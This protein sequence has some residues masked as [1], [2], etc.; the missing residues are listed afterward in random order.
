MADSEE[1]VDGARSNDW[2]DFS[3]DVGASLSQLARASLRRDTERGRRAVRALVKLFKRVALAT[4]IGLIAGALGASFLWSMQFACDFFLA[5]ERLG[6]SGTSPRALFLL[7]FAGLAIV[8]AYKRSGLSVDAG[9]DQVVESLGNEESR[10][11]LWLVP[12]IFFSSVATQLFGGS[13]GREGAALQLGGGIGEL[14]GRA[15]RFRASDLKTALI[16]GMS[17]GFGA[18]FGAPLAAAIFALEIG[19]VGV[20]YYPAFLP[21]LISS[22]LGAAISSY[23]GFTPLTS[24]FAG[25]PSAG[26]WGAGQ[27]LCLGLLCGATCI[28]FCSTIRRFGRSFRRRFP[29]DYLR[30]FFGGLCVVVATCLLGTNAYNGVGATLIQDALQGRAGAYDFLL[31]TLMTA[32]TLGAG[33]KGGEIVP[34]LAVGS[35][36]GCVA[37]PWV[38]LDPQLGAAF[39][40]IALFCGTTN[41]PLASLALSVELFGSENALLFAIVC[42][43][44]YMTSG[45]LGLYKSQ[46]ILF[47]KFTDDLE[48]TRLSAT[49]RHD[50]ETLEGVPES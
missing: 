15:F 27:A 13:A 41:C 18:V 17:G 37:G 47:S 46:R 32:F 44:T 14:F 36:F 4:G 21:A 22:T 26:V 35:T 38:G 48:D 42:G 20:V 30:V 43:A 28:F 12:L 33:F 16:C 29:N 7:P 6:T 10:P 24:S 50:L 2:D 11:S 31:K 40:M 9:T 3:L 1:R 49:L 45:R 5:S 8:F 39:G 23:L 34:A 25:V 19:C